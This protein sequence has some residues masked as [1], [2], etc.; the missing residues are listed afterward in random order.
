MKLTGPIRLPSLIAA[1]VFKSTV[2][3]GMLQV[4]SKFASEI[5]D[6]RPSTHTWSDLES[7][8]RL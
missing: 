5:V 4:P 6:Y 1:R 8:S 2:T 3:E 7:I